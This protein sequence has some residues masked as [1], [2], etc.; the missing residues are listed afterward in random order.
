MGEHLRETHVRKQFE[1]WIWLMNAFFSALN[2]VKCENLS[3]CTEIGQS[4]ALEYY[5]LATMYWVKYFKYYEYIV[6]TLQLNLLKIIIWT[7]LH[8]ERMSVELYHP[9]NIPIWKVWDWTVMIECAGRRFIF[10]T[11]FFHFSF[12]L[13]N[14]HYDQFRNVDKWT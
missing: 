8:H 13:L 11:N 3:L 4:R 7:Q 14:Y 12:F 9:K 2:K 5:P 1:T 10:H 6:P